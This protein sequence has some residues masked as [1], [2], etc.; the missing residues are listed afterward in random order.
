MTVQFTVYKNGDHFANSEKIE[1]AYPPAVGSLICIDG[2]FPESL[3][4]EWETTKGIEPFMEVYEV[5]WW[6]NDKADCNLK[7]PE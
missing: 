6:R 1:M 4:E 2:F 7:T 5:V 3:D